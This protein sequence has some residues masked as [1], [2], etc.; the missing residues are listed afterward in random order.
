MKKQYGLYAGERR[1]GKLDVEYNVGPDKLDCKATASTEDGRVHTP[2]YINRS[3]KRVADAAQ[4]ALNEYLWG[5]EAYGVPAHVVLVRLDDPVLDSLTLGA[6]D[7][8][9]D[10]NWQQSRVGRRIWAYDTRPQDIHL[11][12]I[13]YG[14]RD[15]RFANQTLGL[16]T[17][18]VL[19]HS[20]HATTIGDPSPKARMAKLLHD[21][22]EGTFKDM[23]KPLRNHP[24][25]D[26]YNAACDARQRVINAW[27]GLDP[28]AHH[29]HDVKVADMTMLATERRDLMAPNEHLWSKNPH[30]P[31]PGRVEVWPQ[32]FAV[33]AFLYLFRALAREVC[34]HRE[35]EADALFVAHIKEMREAD[36]HPHI[37][38]VEKALVLS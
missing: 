3:Y 26:A 8:D 25:M 34:P 14:L 11:A 7:R 2:A 22:H 28:D 6:E 27:A 12:E 15:G 35:A 17:Y 16:Y 10:T 29:A 31:L 20:C 5:H 21:A 30:E 23:P 37:Q 36:I 9:A 24:G 33:Y 18:T 1:V 38:L 13:A 4:N 32:P 19:Q